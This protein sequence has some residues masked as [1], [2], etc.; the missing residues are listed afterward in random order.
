MGSICSLSLWNTFL[1]NFSP[2]ALHKTSFFFSF[3]LSF[4]YKHLPRAIQLPWEVPYSWERQ[5]T[6]GRHFGCLQDG[7]R[8]G[9]G[10][11]PEGL[12]SFETK[13]M[14]NVGR[15]ES[16]VVAPHPPP[17][18]LGSRKGR[19]P[20]PALRW[21][22]ICLRQPWQSHPSFWVSLAKKTKRKVCLQPLFSRKK[23]EPQKEK[24]FCLCTFFLPWDVSIR[25]YAC[26]GHSG[27]LRWW[28][29]KWRT[30][31]QQ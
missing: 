16:L 12:T 1:P 29:W 24:G 15:P 17:P 10:R 4:P 18:S 25:I 9:R 26:Y 14:V 6:R 11:G 3:G 19:D 23:A 28:V 7:C 30:K 22:T 13:H 5:E 2:Q 20:S 21:V 27:N 8:H 31:K